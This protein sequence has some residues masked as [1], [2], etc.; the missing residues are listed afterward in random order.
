[1]RKR[2]SKRRWVARFRIGRPI[3]WKA[4]VEHDLKARLVP[5]EY[6]A[7]FDAIKRRAA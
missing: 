3:P 5:A 1:M 2:D 4:I 6:L 7:N